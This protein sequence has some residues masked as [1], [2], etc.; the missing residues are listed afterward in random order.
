MERKYYLHKFVDDIIFKSTNKVLL[1]EFITLVEKK[2]EMG[3]LGKLNFFLRIINK[4]NKRENTYSPIQ[5][6]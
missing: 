2:F 5:I 6:Y 4:V 1:K 3:I